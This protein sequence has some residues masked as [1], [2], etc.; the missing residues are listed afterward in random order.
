MTERDPYAVLGVPCTPTRRRRRGV[1][2]PGA[3]PPSRRLDRIPM[4]SGMAEINAAWA[5]LRDPDRRAAWDRANLRVRDPA[6]ARAGAVR[7]YAQ[8]R[9]RAPVRRLR[10]PAPRLRRVPDRRP[11]PATLAWRRGTP[12]RGR[13]RTTARTARGAASSRSGATSAGRSGRSPGRP[14]LPRVAQRPP[15][16]RPVPGRDRADAR[17]VGRLAGRRTEDDGRAE[18]A[19]RPVRLA[20]QRRITIRSTATC[21]RPFVPSTTSSTLCVPVTANGLNSTCRGSNVPA[22]RST[23]LIRA[24][25]T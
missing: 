6:P 21:G 8:P 22:R 17:V 2:R 7:P 3:P 14:G 1:P 12:R 15:R 10:P 4:P 25:S 20:G 11:L 16:G 18:E 19:A 9:H 5:T 13:G 24:P 23:T